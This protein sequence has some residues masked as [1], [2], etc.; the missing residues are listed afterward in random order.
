MLRTRMCRAGK[1]F[2]SMAVDLRGFYLKVGALH[3]FSGACETTEVPAH[4]C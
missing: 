2:Y 3:C 1:E 4:G